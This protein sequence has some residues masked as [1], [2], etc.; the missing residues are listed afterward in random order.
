MPKKLKTTG[1]AVVT[2]NN[3]LIELFTIRYEAVCC[4]NTKIS[5]TKII[6]VEIKEL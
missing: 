5:G 4:R 1:W 3:V 6:K 2:K